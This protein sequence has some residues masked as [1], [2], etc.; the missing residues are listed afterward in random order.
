MDYKL[1]ETKTIHWDE[2]G[3]EKINRD[4]VIRWGTTAE[5][6]KVHEGKLPIILI[7]HPV[8]LKNEVSIFSS[9]IHTKALLT[10]NEMEDPLK[11]IIKMS[12][13][14]YSKQVAEF[15]EMGK[16]T[17]IQFLEI[18]N[19]DQRPDAEFNVAYNLRDAAIERQ[20]VKLL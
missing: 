3:A 7:G 4:C 16:G 14:C 9:I 2:E 13:E 8:I 19:I 12:R 1:Y 18:S 10:F 15:K 11:Y 17:I 6:Y 20:L 5:I